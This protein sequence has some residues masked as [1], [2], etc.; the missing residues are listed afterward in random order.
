M[1]QRTGVWLWEVYFLWVMEQIRRR[2]NDFDIVHFHT[3]EQFGAIYGFSRRTVS[4][5]HSKVIDNYDNDQLQCYIHLS[6]I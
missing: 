4:T 6:F 2:A 1:K 3:A 5:I